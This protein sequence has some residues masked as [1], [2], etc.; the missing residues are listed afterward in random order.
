MAS[1]YGVHGTVGRCYPIFRDMTLCVA[2]T[3]DPKQCIDLRDDY[4]ECL[5]H[6]KE[7]RHPSAHGWKQ[8]EHAI[9]IERKP[10]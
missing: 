9:E 10:R 5:H 4:F 8:W 2:S 7:V 3:E 6:R 1:G